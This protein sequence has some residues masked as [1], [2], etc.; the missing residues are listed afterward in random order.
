VHEE[1]CCT[2][3]GFD[4]NSEGVSC[5]SSHP[6]LIFTKFLRQ[7]Y[8]IPVKTSKSSREKRKFSNSCHGQAKKDMVKWA[9]ADC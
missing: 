3:A 8:I 1:M 5:N 7:A 2:L 6:Y 4:V 9:R